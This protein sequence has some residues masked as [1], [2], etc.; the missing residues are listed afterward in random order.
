MGAPKGNKNAEGKD[1]GRKSAYQEKQDATWHAEKW[2]L[3]QYRKELERKI[4]SGVYSVRDMFLY[5][6][7]DGN[8]RI[9]TIFANK[10][11]PDLVKHSGDEEN[12][13]WTAEVDSDQLKR[14]ISR[15]VHKDTTK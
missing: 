3:D 4:A 8:E 10:L 15:H 7:L 11:L 2:E 5:K 14:F 12:P 1:S 13:I 6:A 9:L